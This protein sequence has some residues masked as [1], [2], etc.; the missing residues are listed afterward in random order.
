MGEKML[1]QRIGQISVEM[2]IISSAMIGLLLVMFVVNDFLNSSWEELKQSMQASAAAD[3]VAHAINLASAGGNGT[4]ISFFNRVGPDVVRI[5]VFGKRSIRAYYTA[6]G[7]ASAALVTNNTNFNSDIP[8][9]QI[10]VFQNSG[11]I[12][13]GG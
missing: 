9:N 6:G 13:S 4:S 1:S 10:V 11:G 5:E 12:I 8:I 7:Y 3:Q 2:V